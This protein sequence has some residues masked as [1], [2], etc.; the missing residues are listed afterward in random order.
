VIEGV[1]AFSDGSVGSILD[2]FAITNDSGDGLGLFDDVLV[3]NCVIRDCRGWGVRTTAG[4]IVRN[5]M[6]RN[7]AGGIQARTTLRACRH[8]LISENLLEENGRTGLDLEDEGC[9]YRTPHWMLAEHNRIRTT[10]SPTGEALG[11]DARNTPRLFN[12]EI[13]GTEGMGV[14]LEGW[15]WEPPPLPAPGAPLPFHTIFG[16]T[17]PA[18]WFAS[19]NT[20]LMTLSHSIL[21]ANSGGDVLNFPTWTDISYTMSEAPLPGTG[22]LDGVDPMFVPGPGGTT[23]L[24]QIAA[25]QGA[26]SPALDAGGVTAV[27]AGLAY[28]TT[29]TG[30][31]R[32]TGMVD[33]G[34][35]AE[36]W[37]YT[38]FRGTDP[39]GLPAHIPDVVLPV[40]DAGAVG[41]STPELLFYEVDSDEWILLRR[42]GTD[43]QL[44]FQYQQFD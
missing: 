17:G 15:G 35:H 1:L 29:R 6:L 23:Y 43:V 40:T 14:V 42:D 20:W 5:R 22:N 24:S 16:S 21:W 18:V 34:F 9:S 7:T 28:R 12:N 13:V 41:P 11:I 27:E 3:R 44:R 2:G 19:S 30:G 31:V 36:P 8:I 4:R 25:G 38:V 37:S 33:L 39:Q 26:D 32:D 10:R